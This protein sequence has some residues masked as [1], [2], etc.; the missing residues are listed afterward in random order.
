MNC[1]AAR[2]LLEQG[3][4][5]G[6][7]PPERAVLGFHLAG[8]ADCRAYRAHLDDQLL[9]SLLAA[10]ETRSL[11]AAPTLSEP[12][13][14]GV[15]ARRSWRT[16]LS[17]M[18]WYGSLGLLATFLLAVVIVAAGAA[19]S[20]FNIHRNVQAMIVPTTGAQIEQ[21]TGVPALP[22]APA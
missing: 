12:A 13:I 6:S 3:L 16:S 7:S 10:Y 11:S 4:R 8:C 22:A 2:R 21:P 17:Q 18:L 9:N 20:I 1:P 5:P 19:L 14:N 15:V